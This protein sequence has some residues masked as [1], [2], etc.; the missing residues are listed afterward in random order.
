MTRKPIDIRYVHAGD[1]TTNQAH[2]LAW[3]E[4]DTGSRY[5]EL[6][7]VDDRVVGAWQYDLEWYRGVA[8][9]NSSRTGVAQRFKRRGIAQA[10]WMQGIARWRPSRIEAVI[11]TD[12]GRDFLA[13]MTAR[14]AYVAPNTHLWVKCRAEDNEVWASLCEHESRE[15][16]RRLGRD[17]NAAAT[18][19]L[20]AKP[21]QPLLRAAS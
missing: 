15:L 8:R 3:L 12:E 2:E 16:L 17:R 1:L 7:I 6:A 13:R 10:M 14:I 11:A 20:A 19:K 21:A 4:G 5:Q 9:I 18:K